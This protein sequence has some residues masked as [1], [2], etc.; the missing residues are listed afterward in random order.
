MV[1]HKAGAFQ[2][3]IVG[4]AHHARVQSGVGGRGHFEAGGGN[5]GAVHGGHAYG[6]RAAAP[7]EGGIHRDAALQAP[8]GDGNA[9]RIE[10]R[11]GRCHVRHREGDA[12]HAHA[13]LRQAI[14]NFFACLGVE[15]LGHYDVPGRHRGYGDRKRRPGIGSRV[16]RK[17]LRGVTGKLHEEGAV[18]VCLLVFHRRGIALRGEGDEILLPGRHLRAGIAGGVGGGYLYAG[19]VDTAGL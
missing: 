7:R 17:L 16:Q 3:R 18:G 4:I 10:V 15:D 13:R 5:N 12:A 8:G 1:K 6:V 2:R 9:Q 11:R 19:G 14:C